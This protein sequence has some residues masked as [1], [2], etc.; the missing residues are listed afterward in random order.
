MNGTGNDFIVVDNRSRQVAEARLAEFAARYCPRR[1]AVG[2]DGVLLVE[3]LPDRS[4]DFRMRYFNA[5]GSEADMCGNGARC[6]ACFAHS[7]G[8]AGQNMRFLTGAGPV[9][10]AITA[11]GAVI[12]MPQPT[13]PEKR[14]VTVRGEG[15]DLWFLS[16]G[17]PHAVLPVADLARADVVGLGRE[18]RR[19]EA[20]APAG[21]NVNFVVRRGNGLA[22]R[23]YERGVEDETLACGTGASASA[24]AAAAMWGLASPI[25]VEVRGGTL[26]IHFDRHGDAFSHLRLEGPAV[27]VYRGELDWQD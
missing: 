6:I 8:A 18:L 13:N 25:E 9:G 16:T 3:E 17:V 12:D 27:A 26:R 7:I 4:A 24:L 22:I 20:F 23:T 1:T 21:T 10:A 14:R 11:R 19:H 15:L 5:D 2:A